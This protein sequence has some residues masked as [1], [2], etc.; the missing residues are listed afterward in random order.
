MACAAARAFSLF[1]LESQC[2]SAAC[3]EFRMVSLFEFLS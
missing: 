1:M 2:G 3:E